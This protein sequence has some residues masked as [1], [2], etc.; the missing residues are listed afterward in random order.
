M[1]RDLCPVLVVLALLPAGCAPVPETAY[2]R[3]P[4]PG[5]EGRACT[6]AC[7]TEAAACA[8]TCREERFRCEL[9]RDR[10]AQERYR[11]HVDRQRALGQEVQRSPYDFEAP[12]RCDRTPCQ[13]ACT[14]TLNACWT[15]CGGTV[16]ERPR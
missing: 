12:F 9:A 7:G 4:P 2:D 6:A 16:T 3:A 15:G 10:W 5:A 14:A 1:M 11:E 13:D 8:D